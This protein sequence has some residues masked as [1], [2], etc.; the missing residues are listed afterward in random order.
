MI[1]ST[2]NARIPLSPRK[3]VS[4]GSI[5][6]A[7]AGLSTPAIPADPPFDPGF[8]PDLASRLRAPTLIWTCYT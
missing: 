3:C 6:R 5:A 7:A 2:D 8:S 1:A 4:F